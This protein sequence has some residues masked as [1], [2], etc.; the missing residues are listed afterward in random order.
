MSVV[1]RPIARV[2][3]RLK[4]TGA[5][6]YTADLPQD[7]GKDL[8]HA[9]A[10]CA[11]VAKG[12]ITSID[13][14]QARAAGGVLELITHHNAPRL[15]PVPAQEV[16]GPAHETLL[17][18]QDD[19]VHY[20]GQP[21]AV[22][23]A[24]TLENATHAA[25]LVR[26][27]YAEERPV[28]TLFEGI[29]DA[30]DSPRYAPPTTIGDVDRG[31][32]DAA[33]VIDRTYTTPAQ[34]HHPMETMATTVRWTADEVTVHVSTQTISMVR[35]GLATTFGLRPEQVRV[36]SEFLGGGFGGKAAW[37]WPS[38]VTAMAAR[39][40]GRQVRL[41]TTR[42]QMFAATGQRPHS[43]QR[44]RLGARRD[45]VLTAIAQDC[46]GET[47]AFYDTP[48][49]YIGAATPVP[50][51]CPNIRTTQRFVKVN[52]QTPVPMRSPVEGV[53]LVSVESA[54]D[55]L[56]AEL[57]VDPLEL[58]RRNYAERD[59]NSGL[60]WS[61]NGLLEC[62]ERGARRFGWPER[63][64][65]PRS[66]RDGRYLVGWGMATAIR[67]AGSDPT[68]ALVR[69][70]ADGRAV[71]QIGSQ[72]LGTGTFTIM[73]QV[74]A[75]ALGVPVEMMRAELGDTDLPTGGG[76]FG[77]HTAASVAAAARLAGEA[78]RAKVIRIAVADEGS[79]LSG[80]SP[81][82]VLV[83]DGYLFVRGDRSRGERYAQIL[84]R[85][86]L[87]SAT[88]DHTPP[89]RE[90]ATVARWAFGADFTE[91]KVDPELGTV[92]VTRHVKAIEAGRIINPRTARSQVIG[93]VVMGIGQAL[94]EATEVDRRDARITN[95]G[96]WGYH[97][98]VNADVPDIE[99]IFV[100]RDDPHIPG[101][102][103]GLGEIATIGTAPAILN[104]VFHATGKR[105]RDLPIT[106]DKLL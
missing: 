25:S 84:R 78:L 32:A 95:A 14:R 41:V 69:L 6:R 104:A 85:N 79:P 90:G 28:A 34:H 30:F 39:L 60:P 38:V 16:L 97:V 27:E 77:S 81:D 3:G 47:S 99:A 73:T 43:V 58:R 56:A 33:V 22:V 101:S 19:R 80:A 71:V 1:G 36:V 48:P 83:D 54:M 52:C 88:G 82:D 62:Y 68:S 59:P 96:F 106:P 23:V 20:S 29:D 13:A 98:P 50:Y 100:E 91:V 76:S 40:T 103:K 35:D 57:G 64:P 18:L 102:V 49:F 75:D 12:R 63:N 74:A 5:A 7:D 31:L 46:V 15:R 8:V 92:R 87:Q 24:D 10:V 37:C 44:V 53:G 67:H 61:S 21:V 93:G 2:E 94:T 72:D 65:E 89:P 4:V 26:V 9:V 86:R 66:M 51:G 105:V 42:R 17:V 11:A 55:E 45:G 70:G